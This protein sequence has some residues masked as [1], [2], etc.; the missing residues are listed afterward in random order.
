MEITTIEN[1]PK[2]TV[3]IL[4]AFQT[5]NLDECLE[6]LKKTNYPDY[7]IIVVDCL[8]PGITDFIQSKFSYV[9]LISLDEDIGPAAMHNVGTR[10]AHPH[11]KYISFLD[12]DIAVESNWLKELVLCI[13][14]SD[15]IGAVQSKI[16]LY[17]QPNLFN[18][19][20]NKANYLVVGWPDGYNQ[21]DNGEQLIKEISFPSGA[22]MIMRREA[23]EKVGG[24]DPDFFIYADDMD[25]GLRI[26]IAGYRILYCPKSVIYHK[27]KFLKNS[28]NFY[29]L[30]RNRLYSFFKI[31]NTTTYLKLLI[32]FIFYEFSVLGYAILN[33]FVKQLLNAYLYHIKN[34]RTIKQKRAEILKYK[35]LTD[36][37]II[38]KLEGRIEF[39]EISDHPAVKYFLNPLLGG[40]RKLLVGG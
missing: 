14:S 13:D 36:Y 22:S 2:V 15:D 23:L 34:Y 29:Y 8:T 20:G 5:I 21:P 24:Y 17:H 4:N 32:P 12:N 9:K 19:R 38:C 30:N 7:E 35:V 18:T 11:S 40:Y 31:Y 1:W 33:G 37:E 25:A 10:N 3:V 26:M 6:S 16:M 27:Y 28:R 39:P